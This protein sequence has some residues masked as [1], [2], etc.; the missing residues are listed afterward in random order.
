MYI[1]ILF[2]YIYIYIHTNMSTYIIYGLTCWK[3]QRG[4]VNPYI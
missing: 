2:I 3:S 4:N 1:H